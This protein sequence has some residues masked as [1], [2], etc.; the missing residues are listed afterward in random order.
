[1]VSFSRSVFLP[2]TNLCRNRCSY[3][4]FRRNPEDG[5]WFLSEEEVLELARQGKEHGCSEALF[6]LGER[7]EIYDKAK[8]RLD[9]WGHS[10]TVDYL[11][12]LCKR[13]LDLGLF[14]HVNPG[15]LERRELDKLKEW[16]ASMGLMLESAAELPV[17]DE[18]PGKDPNLRLKT[19]AEAGKLKIPFTTG[20][21]VGIGE[22]R[23]ERTE[24][25]LKIRDLDRR[26]GHIQEVIIQP[27]APK[28]GT[29][30]SN[31]P[32]PP[33][34]KI[35]STV[36]EARRLMPEMNIQV[37][38]N[39]TD[40]DNVINFL[41]AGANDLGGISS[42]TPDFINPENLWPSVRELR[43]ILEPNGFKLRER[44]PIYPEFVSDDRFMSVEIRSKIRKMTD[45]DGY[46]R[47]PS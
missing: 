32:P 38:P 14:P 35:L 31:A 40:N 39:L 8:E 36:K 13:V 24:A 25:L 37:P 18:S 5:A 7:P 27:F 2:V 26:Y 9:E 6:T 30:M 47:V 15:I 33:V 4:G 29:P 45:E 11:E 3:C 28:S 41:R 43:G 23:K 46:R 21:L 42:L 22:S 17:H 12:D 19:I 34:S 10:S 1:M 20:L 16:S 44:L